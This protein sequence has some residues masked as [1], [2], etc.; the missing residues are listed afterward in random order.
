MDERDGV[1]YPEQQT[2]YRQSL[3][4]KTKSE[5]KHEKKMSKTESR[6]K[7]KL[8]SLKKLQHSASTNSAVEKARAFFRSLEL[9]HHGSSSSNDQ[10]SSASPRRRHL[11]TA[12]NIDHST[13]G[14][15]PP[16]S[17]VSSSSSSSIIDDSQNTISLPTTTDSSLPIKNPTDG[18]AT[19]RLIRVI[20]SNYSNSK[21]MIVHRA[22]YDDQPPYF[23]HHSM[24]YERNF[25]SPQP[26]YNERSQSYSVSMEKHREVQAK[27]DIRPLSPVSSMNSNIIYSS[28]IYCN[29]PSSIEPMAM[30]GNITNHQLSTSLYNYR[31]L[32]CR[33]IESPTLMSSSFHEPSDRISD[34]IIRPLPPSSSS[35]SSMSTWNQSVRRLNNEYTSTINA[36]QQAKESLKDICPEQNNKISKYANL[37]ARGIDNLSNIEPKKSL[38]VTFC[39]TAPMSSPNSTTNSYDENKS[40]TSSMF[41]KPKL[42][43]PLDLDTFVPSITSLPKLEPVSSIPEKNTKVDSIASIIKKF[44]NLNNSP[45]SLR[46]QTIV[47]NHE[48]PSFLSQFTKEQ[49]QQ[50]LPK[51]IVFDSIPA[52]KDRPNLP[53]LPSL[54][55]LSPSYPVSSPRVHF[56][57][58]VTT[59]E[60]EEIPYE[61]PPPPLLS[62]SSSS[63]TSTSI[64]EDSTS[65]SSTD[66]NQV[67]ENIR[68]D[69][70]VQEETT[71]T[72]ETF[73]KS[74]HN[75]ETNKANLSNQQVVVIRE[76]TTEEQFNSARERI[77]AEKS[78]IR[79]SPLKHTF[80]TNETEVPP[81]TTPLLTYLNLTVKQA[82]PTIETKDEVHE[83]YHSIEPSSA[84]HI[85]NNFISSIYRTEENETINDVVT[86]NPHTHSPPSHRLI[87]SSSSSSTVSSA[88][89]VLISQKTTSVNSNAPNGNLTKNNNKSV[90][91]LPKRTLSNTPNTTIT[92]ASR[93]KQPLKNVP[94][95]SKLKPP[96]STIKKPLKPTIASHMSSVTPSTMATSSIRKPTGI[97]NQ[98]STLPNNVVNRTIQQQVSLTPLTSTGKKHNLVNG[99]N[100]TESQNL[101]ESSSSLGKNR[102]RSMV[103]QLNAAVSST[104]PVAPVAIP[105][106]RTPLF[107]SVVNSRHSALTEPS[108]SPPPT[109]AITK[110][111]ITAPSRPTLQRAMTINMNRSGATSPPSTPSTTNNNIPSAYKRRTPLV[112]STSNVKEGLLRWCQAQVASYPNVS[113][114]N[115]SSSWA[116]GLAFCAL[117]H[118]F[119]PDAF[120]FNSL[121]SSN[122]KENF[123]LAFRVAEERA[124]VP[125]LLDVS[126]MLIMGNTP[127]YKCIFTYLNSFLAKVKDLHPTGNGVNHH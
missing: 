10:S 18:I 66:E 95:S 2:Q 78:R 54:T 97:T 99:T 94:T 40:V 123:E 46:S 125:Q 48:E 24:L 104:R 86:I 57:P 106:K 92:N 89:T 32:V 55:D 63:S 34:S 70:I 59:Y 45:V 67:Y 122:R 22:I 77:R 117:T 8:E 113:V 35:S 30:N 36:L 3:L 109:P 52:K 44:N 65:S 108:T 71:Y 61:S 23:S 85:S 11:T 124:G 79:H 121:S 111:T 112:R 16:P 118:H 110:P 74:T 75:N 31:P 33:H 119:F 39:L 6:F 7:S 58:S 101:A 76:N 49:Q 14:K 1:E 80:T 50:V 115:L 13:S 88:S 72:V 56:E 5:I 91:Q 47:E 26:F 64:S 81:L 4:K 69:N 87:S 127:D 28:Q 103:N 17:S 12:N 29:S 107:S 20:N 27:Y 19:A 98:S 51:I 41:C 84:A 100:M 90:S 102:V 37:V 114:T 83:N 53:S 15:F 60:I 93:L 43:R 73:Y 82:S 62:S 42:V 68:C 21:D 9:K 105:T 38:G 116:D 96:S 120:D 25:P 126:D